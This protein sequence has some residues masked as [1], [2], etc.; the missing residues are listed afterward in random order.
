MGKVVGGR[1][2][3]ESQ[4]E[5]SDDGFVDHD[6]QHHIWNWDGF[7][8]KSILDFDDSKLIF[9]LMN[10]LLDIGDSLNDVFDGEKG[11]LGPQH[12]EYVKSDAFFQ[13]QQFFYT[14]L[15]ICIF[16]L[17]KIKKTHCLVLYLLMLIFFFLFF[18]K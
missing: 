1:I 16:F 3:L 9:V 17:Q 14:F 4:L 13:T 15:V 7:E 6:L 12:V 18:W 5:F 8:G 10:E 2:G 11:A